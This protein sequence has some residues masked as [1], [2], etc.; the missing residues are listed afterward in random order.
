MNINFLLYNVTGMGGTVRVVVTL[1]NYLAENGYDVR[2]FSVFRGN[3][4]PFFYVDPRINIEFLVDRYKGLDVESKDAEL[5]S[6]NSELIPED[7]ED[8][9]NFSLLSDKKI[10]EVLNSLKGEVLITT[11]TSFNLIASKYA[12]KDVCVIGQEHLNFSIYS[13]R[14]K[15]EIV[16]NYKN[17]DYLITLTG[18]DTEEYIEHLGKSN[19]KIRQI[20]NGVPA[21]EENTP[22]LENKVIMAAG[23]IVEQKGFDL[24]VCAYNLLRNDYPDWKIKIYGSGKDEIPL[25][26]L[27][28]EIG[29]SDN[30]LFMGP[31]DNI[32]EAFNDASIFA[33][34]SRYEG[35]GMVIVEAM[36]CGIPVVSFNCP[37]GPA[38]II[39]NG[40]DG[41]IVKDGDVVAF[42]KALAS[43]MDNRDERQRLGSNASENIKRFLIN[44]VGKKWDELFNE[45]DNKLRVEKAIANK[46]KRS[47]SKNTKKKKK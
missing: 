2:I 31:T 37:K 24:L 25:K 10:L 11:R 43:L 3:E 42:A 38:E 23:R 17:L 45:I 8:Y 4:S 35:F 22:K 30:I 20:T 32:Q 47:K 26:K 46:S 9:D 5:D 34:S 12:P 41:I 40:E 15:Y 6:F 27:V 39:R 18:G 7:D 36:Q 33:L 16:Q 1:A 13:P 19:V 28:D 44:E 14:M 29:L 21:I